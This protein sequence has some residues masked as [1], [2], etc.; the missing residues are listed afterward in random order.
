MTND[1]EN[2]TPEENAAEN[3]LPEIPEE[4]VPE[5]PEVP[6][7]E[8]EVEPAAEPAIVP[9][10]AKPKKKWWTA[11]KIIAFIA[12]IAGAL[13]I[14]TV[15]GFVLGVTATTVADM[16]INDVIPGGTDNILDELPGQDDA[17]PIPTLAPGELPSSMPNIG[18]A[19]PVILNEANPV[20][21]VAEATMDSVVTITMYETSLNDDKEEV[22]TPLGYSTGTIISKDGYIVTNYHVVENGSVI[23]VT[24]SD[25]T[26]QEA[27][28]VGTDP[29]MD[30]AV[31]KIAPA[32]P[33][34]PIPLGNSSASRV[35]DYAIAIGNPV[36]A[37]ELLTN[38]VTVGY[39]SAVDREMTFNDFRQKFIQMDTPVNPGNSGGPV[40]NAKG[41]CIGFVTWKSLISGYD[42]F[43]NPITT[44]GVSFAIPMNS[45]LESIESIILTGERP[46][47]GLGITFYPFDETAA[48]A[49]G[50]DAT[51][52]EIAGFLEGSPC[53][54][55]GIAVGDIIT[56]MNGKPITDTSAFSA[57]VQS[58]RVGDRVTFK[59]YRHG[60]GYFEVEVT[61]MDLNK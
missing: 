21:E 45:A 19:A 15:F 39:I 13:L 12:I 37:G 49:A 47:A 28:L 43:G 33:L 22:Y 48:E 59:V 3:N 54:T 56:H 6:E 50:I 34:K 8:P 1:F 32:R 20:P 14:G 23:L 46:R 60:T 4:A 25:G 44:E 27:V 26:E 53:E 40:M 35:G 57:E 31:I 58:M 41:E 16:D 17:D 61:L 24:L 51:G 42:D 55:A 2:V 9:A 11:G 10:P 52:I 7:A 5:T 18:G 36:G 29:Y 38:T 30:L